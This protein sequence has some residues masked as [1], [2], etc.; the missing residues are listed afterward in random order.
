MTT[1]AV[2]LF[3]RDYSEDRLPMHPCFQLVANCEQV[4]TKFTSRR[5]L[6]LEKLHEPQVECSISEDCR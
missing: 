2:F 5:L 3:R 1:C 4:L 6:T